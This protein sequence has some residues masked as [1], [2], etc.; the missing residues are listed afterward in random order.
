MARTESGAVLTNE[1][2][3]A[4]VQLRARAL[5]DYIRVWPLWQGDEQSFTRLVDATIPLVRAHHRMSAALAAAY[6]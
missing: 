3:Q 6:Y 1:H 2:R 5:Q 4:Q